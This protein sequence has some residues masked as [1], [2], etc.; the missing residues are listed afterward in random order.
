MDSEIIN[1]EQMIGSNNKG[2]T[3]AT[4]I[5]SRVKD[6]SRSQTS[7]SSNA[8][9]NDPENLDYEEEDVVKMDDDPLNKSNENL[10]HNLNETKET[11]REIQ[12]NFNFE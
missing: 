10:S 6:R 4:T 8:D 3:T 7:I 12:V 5:K 1:D 11:S 2:K 9:I